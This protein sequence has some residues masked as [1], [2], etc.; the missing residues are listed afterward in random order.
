VILHTFADPGG[1]L[2]QI[3]GECTISGD[4]RFDSCPGVLRFTSIALDL[5]W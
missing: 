3:P 5:K 4:I 1:G 2:N